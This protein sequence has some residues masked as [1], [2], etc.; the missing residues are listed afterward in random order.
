MQHQ[1]LLDHDRGPVTWVID[2]SSDETIS[3]GD[4][5]VMLGMTDSDLKLGRFQFE[6]PY[7]HILW[8][9]KMPT[10]GISVSGATLPLRSFGT[11]SEA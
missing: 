9:V 2:V 4:S 8:M 10:T 6:S 5:H 1:Q 3:A 7:D 11:L